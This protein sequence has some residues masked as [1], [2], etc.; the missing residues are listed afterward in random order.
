[1]TK[2]KLI[3]LLPFK[4]VAEIFGIAFLISSLSFNLRRIV[5]SDDSTV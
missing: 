3:V 2:S 5:S 1:V 4:E